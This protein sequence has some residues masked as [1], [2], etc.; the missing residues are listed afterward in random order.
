MLKRWYVIILAITGLLM[1]I[2]LAVG[3][4]AA[5]SAVSNCGADSQG[6]TPVVC[7]ELD[8]GRTSNTNPLISV[9]GA[10]ISIL[11]YV[12]GIAAVVGVVVSGLRLIT[13]NGDS[14][15]VASARSGLIYSLVGVAVAIFAQLIVVFILNKI[16]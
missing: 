6:G 9:I 14:G 16:Q 1:P 2:G 3:Q 10:A 8:K 15:G 5:V 7:Q 4:A 12:I 11:A 13:S